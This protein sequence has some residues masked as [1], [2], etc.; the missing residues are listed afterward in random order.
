MT[1]SVL[2]R[3]AVVISANAA[4]FQKSLAQAQNG[5]KGFTSDVKRIAGA[6][7]LAF[8]VQQIAA[9]A[10]DV[11]KLAG[12]AR[13]VKTAFDRLPESI[14]LM[15][16]L[17]SATGGTVSELEL[18]KRAVQASNFDISL[19]ALPKLLEFATLRAQQTG[20]SVDYLV[21]SIV[22]GIGR[23]SKLI[24]DNLGISATQL[25]QKLKG[26]S[27]E[28]ATVGDVAKAVGEIAEESLK[29]MAGFSEN[30]STK[31]QRLGAS[32]DNLKVSIGSSSGV[33]GGVIRNTTELLDA[34]SGEQ[35][36][37]AIRDIRTAMLNHDRGLD[38]AVNNAAKLV[39]SGVEFN[40]TAQQI[41]D[42]FGVTQLAA[43]KIVDALL[44]AKS[45]ASN[46]ASVDIDPITGLP[47]S[48]AKPWTPPPIE[49]FIQTIETLNAKQKELSEEFEKNPLT[50]KNGHISI[51]DNPALRLLAAQIASY[52][53][54]IAKLESLKKFYSEVNQL[55]IEKLDPKQNQLGIDVKAMDAMVQR[56]ELGLK[57]IRVATRQTS[58]DISNSMVDM[59][60][61]VSGAIIGL[62]DGLGAALVGVE[63]FGDVILK[64]FASFAQQFGGLLIAMGLGKIAFKSF[65]GPQ[66][67]GAGVALVALGGAI[68]GL[69]ANRPGLNGGEG[70]GGS[71]STRGVSPSDYYGT[72]RVD[73]AVEGQISGYNININQVKERY[74]R[75]RTG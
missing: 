75:G 44:R 43:E 31:I 7:G 71:S 35:V 2:A 70:G 67:I 28:A 65:S 15:D 14:N 13:G 58:A 6:V 23:K 25:N 40:F 56:F 29:N 49:K 66:M 52:D 34:L 33:F 32:W 26:V 27:A 9:F 22:T 39:A 68:N 72:G 73:V 46:L 19:Q 11:A 45:V 16:K 61:M 74:R 21:D 10:V 47:T 48:G 1:S 53:R 50:S 20:Q 64:Q 62:A 38:E 60:G 12:E 36:S 4:G 24:L 63:N 37:K 5:L 54:L 41:S 55:Q 8:G 42:R 51:A 30:A 3:L 69:I 17:K 57:R 18:M 59:S